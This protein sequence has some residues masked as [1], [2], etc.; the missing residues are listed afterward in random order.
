[1]EVEISALEKKAAALKSLLE[2]EAARGESIAA[3]DEELRKVGEQLDQ[4]KRM[5]YFPFSA[6]RLGQ[7]GVYLGLQDFWLEYAS[8]SFSLEIS[9]EKGIPVIKVQ[10][11]GT[12]DNLAAGVAARAKLEGFKL[13]G[14]KGSGVPKLAFDNLTVTV[15]FSVTLR[16]HYDAKSAKWMLPKSD[17]KLKIISFKGP[18]GL[19]G[20]IV[21]LVVSLLT[22]TIRYQLLSIIPFELGLLVRTLPCPTVIR[23]QFHVNGV[24]LSLLST[25]WQKSKTLARM[26]RYS[27]QQMEMFY[28]LQKALDRSPT[29]KTVQDLIA[30]IRAHR[31]HGNIWK[32]LLHL[33]GQAEAIYCEKVSMRTYGGFLFCCISPLLF[34]VALGQIQALKLQEAALSPPK[35]HPIAPSVSFSTTTSSSS[36]T[37][38][39]EPSAWTISFNTFITI[40]DELLRKRVSTHFKLQHVESQ[41][42][43]NHLLSFIFQI[44]ERVIQEN[45]NKSSNDLQR[46]RLM[47]LADRIRENYQYALEILRMVAKNLDFAQLGITACLHSGSDG[48]LEASVKEI[49]AQAPL[50]LQFNF[51]KE[52]NIGALPLV[53]YILSVKP[54]TSGDVVVEIYHFTHDSHDVQD[55]EGPSSE[56]STSVRGSV[57]DELSSAGGGGMRSYASQNIRTGAYSTSY[58][59]VVTSIANLKA[60]TNLESGGSSSATGAGT[61]GGLGGGLVLRTGHGCDIASLGPGVLRR[62]ASRGVSASQEHLFVREEERQRQLH[63]ILNDHPIGTISHFVSL[64]M[65]RVDPL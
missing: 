47:S 44:I 22:P 23:G 9:T 10:L 6:I 49:L 27:T 18:Y 19:N 11:M 35:G 21:S 13:V 61:V 37:T 15:A 20:S 5:H 54:Q 40:C 52:K 24:E 12:H 50:L 46:L 56:P 29:M 51:S 42:S 48:Y 45:I 39:F 4:L 14:D 38:S 8:G 60:N 55:L 57:E 3:L 31:V 62:E 26:C 16:L 64:S 28:C 33:W 1:M 30:Y 34:V 17:F 32:Q 2:K 7:G 59:R 65:A 36:A 25:E 41:I 43:V 53:P 58:N 63:E